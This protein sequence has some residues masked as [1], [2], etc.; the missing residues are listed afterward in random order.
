MDKVVSEFSQKNVGCEGIVED[1]FISQLKTILIEKHP[2]RE[3]V[4]EIVTN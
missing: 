1:H 4:I 2:L 3:K